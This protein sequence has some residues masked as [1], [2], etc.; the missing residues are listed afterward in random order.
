[1]KDFYSYC[2]FCGRPMEFSES[3]ARAL[4]NCPVCDA[5]IECIESFDFEKET[6]GYKIIPGV[7]GDSYEKDGFVIENGI[8]VRGDA[9]CEVLAV[10]DGVVAIGE[11]T[12]A[13]NKSI[14]RLHLPS[15]VKYIGKEAF[16]NCE[17][18]RDV[19]LSEEIIAIGNS[20][21]RGCR[22]LES[23]T[24][25]S[26]LR[27]AGYALFH[28]CDNLTELLMPM[29]M[30][31]LGGSP[32]GFCKKLKVANVPHCVTDISSSWFRENNNLQKLY[33]GR[34]VT[35]IRY[36]NCPAL[37]EVYL[38]NTEG[39]CT[40]AWRESDRVSIPDEKMKNPKSAAVIIK[41]NN[42]SGILIPDKSS[43]EDNWTHSYWLELE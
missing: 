17:N 23:V 32:Y 39:W 38:S 21:F 31:Y 26:S 15:S 33:I 42:G 25:P 11:R 7:L 43:P 8:L 20:A 22:R 18:L 6:V 35:S 36:T 27:A 14:R 9:G 1:M 2:P 13:E 4:K 41:K 30:K 3:V 12:F 10:P 16:L 5:P 37:Q 24:I 34:G 29:D 19:R 28:S 40:N